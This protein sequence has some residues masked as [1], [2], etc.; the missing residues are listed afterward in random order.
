MNFARFEFGSKDGHHMLVLLNAAH[1]FKVCR[2]NS[3]LPMVSGASQIKDLYLAFRVR[4]FET[5][6][7][8]FFCH[9]ARLLAG[10]LVK[11]KFTPKFDEQCRGIQP[12]L[13]VLLIFA[14]MIFLSGSRLLF[15]A[16]N[17]SHLKAQPNSDI[18]IA[19]V[20][21]L[22]FDFWAVSVLTLLP[23]ALF[24]ALGRW[25]KISKWVFVLSFA[26]L[27]FPGLIFNLGDT[28]YVNYTGRR[29]TWDTLSAFHEVPGKFVQIVASYGWLAL[30][31]TL[32]FLFCCLITVKLWRSLDHVE[33]KTDG[34]SKRWRVALWCSMSVVLLVGARG[35]LQ[36][37][38][39][40][41]AHAQ[42]FNLPMMNN[43]V[44]NSSFTVLQTIKRQSVERVQFFESQQDLLSHLN[45]SLPGPS[46][47]EGH[48]PSG[49]QNIVLIIVESLSLEYM[50]PGDGY[51][52]FLN[53]LARQGVFFQN[54]IANAKRSIEGIGAIL[55]GIPALMEEPFLSSQYM[56]NYFLGIGSK[57]GEKGY[58]TSFFHGGQNG[59]FY[60]DSFTRS[61]GIQNYFGLNEYPD[62]KDFDGTW[63]IFD[64]PFLQFMVQKLGTFREPFFS[65]VFTLS[66]H[67]PFTVPAQYAGR[68][69]KG[70]GD[71]HESI[72]YS[73]FALE[74]FFKEAQKQPWYK[75]T[76]FIITA[77]HT[78]KS[79]RS[80]WGSEVGAFRIPLILYHPSW[81][82]PQVDVQQ[83]TQQV[84]ILPTILD[85]AGLDEKERNYL[86]RSVF[87]P[88]DRT[89]T[90]YLDQKYHL[91]GKDYFLT[92]QKNAAEDLAEQF[93]FYSHTDEAELKALSEP[94]DLREK[95]VHALK[96]S[97]QY[98][99]QGLWDNKLYY[100]SGR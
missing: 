8:L 48:R 86:G 22:R 89:A 85:F 46:L 25:S 61:V 52:P 17:W 5:L 32:W 12:L 24:L 29:L 21:G 43:L 69:P 4:S 16:W 1:A 19:F 34:L 31:S 81:K 55:G 7:H 40:G 91:I 41:F 100:P 83:I 27:Q 74:Q 66:S 10:D 11:V 39:L 88:G 13:P 36:K 56:T 77:D 15:L 44:L 84:D 65:A 38:P 33:K 80:G 45:G 90:V 59:T 57:L 71:I 93:K 14:T 63:G 87:V 62:K 70:V 82:A 60:I 96:A 26:L 67:N 97:I 78:Y 53:S 73:D 28:E 58:H 42:I 9:D 6:S 23:F 49:K 75:N 94:A 18:L 92:Y 76:L 79:W 3:D 99:S 95:Y 37:K 54:H 72:G 30:W 2:F 50:G 64:E 35:G 47:L 98:F 68:F 51:T 20:A